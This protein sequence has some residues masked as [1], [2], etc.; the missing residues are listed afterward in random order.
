VQP[1]RLDKSLVGGHFIVG[2]ACGSNHVVLLT[3]SGSVLC[4][5]SGKAEQRIAGI[6]AGRIA[7]CFA[8]PRSFR[9]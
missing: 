7:N 8:V 9:G 6:D 5:G 3:N 1:Q 2:I 4:F